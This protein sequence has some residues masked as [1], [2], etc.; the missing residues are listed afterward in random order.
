L[1][2]LTRVTAALRSDSVSGMLLIGAALIALIWANSPLAGSPV[3]P[4][5][6]PRSMVGAGAG[7]L[8]V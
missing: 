3:V 2:A 4:S 6:W 1:P 8:P 5:R 7:A